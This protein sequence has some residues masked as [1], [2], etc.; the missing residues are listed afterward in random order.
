MQNKPGKNQ[1]YAHSKNEDDSK[2]EDS[3]LPPLGISKS[4]RKS[5][6]YFKARNRPD[7]PKCSIIKNLGENRVVYR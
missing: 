2:Q 1:L 7:R 5:K 3:D 6:G 4:R